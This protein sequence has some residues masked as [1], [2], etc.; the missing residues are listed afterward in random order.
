MKALGLVTSLKKKFLKSFQ[1]LITHLLEKYKVV[2]TV[3]GTATEYSITSG[4]NPVTYQISDGDTIQIFGLTETDVYQVNEQDYSA[5]GYTTTNRQ[6]SGSVCADAS[7]ITVTN[8]KEVPPSTGL[9][10]S[11]APFVLMAA[12]AGGFG[13]MIFGRRRKDEE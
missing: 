11:A 9:I 8:E 4:A 1:E 13:A 2:V 12:A 3:D 6:N 7:G 5:D 10:L